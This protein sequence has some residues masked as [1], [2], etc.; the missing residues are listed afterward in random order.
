M[1][2][3]SAKAPF[4]SPDWIFEIKLDGYRAITVFD[5][6]GKPHLWSR[7]GLPLE[8]KFPAV[9]DAVSRLKLCSTILDGEIVAVDENGIPRFQLLQSFQKQPI[10]SS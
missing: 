5:S 2:A 9:A 4:G 8:A 6:A 7:N 1:M 3:D 10:R